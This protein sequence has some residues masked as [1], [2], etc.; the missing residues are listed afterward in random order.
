MNKRKTYPIT[1]IAD[2]LG[3]RE[4][5]QMFTTLEAN[6]GFQQVPIGNTAKALTT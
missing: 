3:S 5:T 4:E 1:S 6:H 2:F